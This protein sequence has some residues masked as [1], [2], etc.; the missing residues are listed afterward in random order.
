MKFVFVCK[1]MKVEFWILD[2][3][4]NFLLS[5]ICNFWGNVVGLCGVKG[6]YIIW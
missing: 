4:L 2:K 1:Y 6:R 3:N 5:L